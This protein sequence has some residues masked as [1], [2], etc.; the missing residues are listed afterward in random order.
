MRNAGVFDFK[1]SRG[2]ASGA[3]AG[4][5]VGVVCKGKRFVMIFALSILVLALVAGGFLTGCKSQDNRICVTVTVIAP[6]Y[7]TDDSPI[8]L[9]FTR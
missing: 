1:P 8:P 3:K 7:S 6:E 9:Q 4:A 5:E 2:N